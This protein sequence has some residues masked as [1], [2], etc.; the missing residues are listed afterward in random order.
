MNETIK[1]SLTQDEVEILV[2]ALEADMEGYVEAAKEARGNGNHDDV[3]TF[4]DA[5]TR[6]QTLMSKLQD[7]VEE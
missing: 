6:I 3:K 5:A 7:Y 2:D 4:T 1:L